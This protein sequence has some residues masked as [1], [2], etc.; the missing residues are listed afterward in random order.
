MGRASLDERVRAAMIDV[1]FEQGPLLVAG[2]LFTAVVLVGLLSG[3]VAPVPLT[4]WS[5]VLAV[6]TA[7]RALLLYRYAKRRSRRSPAPLW[8]WA[9]ALFSTGF[10]LLWGAAALLFIDAGSGYRANAGDLWLVVMIPVVIMGL[11]AVAT[12]ALASFPAAS[13]GFAVSSNLLLVL[14]LF[15]SATE[16]A[17][18]LIALILISLASNLKNGH[19]L[20][21]VLEETLRLRF[22]NQDLRQRF[23]HKSGRLQTTLDNIDQGL[24]LL[25]R[26]GRLAMW[27][28][29]LL[30]LMGAS[31]VSEQTRFDQLSVGLRRVVETDGSYAD[32][33]TLWRR[34]DGACVEIRSTP[35]AD[36]ESVLTV[37]DVTQLERHQQAQLQARFQAEEARRQAEQANIAKTRFLAA[38]SHD[39]RQPVQALAL[40]HRVLEERARG[41][42]LQGLVAQMGQGIETLN[43]LLGNL[44]HISKLEAG[45]EIPERATVEL[46]ALFEQLEREFSRVAAQ[47]H[48]RLRFRP[49]DERVDSDR[50]MLTRIVS[51]LVANAI[52][53]SRNG[54]VLV[55][56]R[57]RGERL[58]IGV[59]D[60]G[61]G[62]PLAHQRRIFEEF[63]QLHNPQRDRSLGLGL[64]LAIVKR[65]AEL[66]GHRVEVRSRVGSGSCFSVWLPRVARPPARRLRQGDLGA[67]PGAMPGARPGAGRDEVLAGRRVWVIDDDP[68]VREALL[69]L[70]DH[71]GCRVQVAADLDAALALAYGGEAADLLLLDYRLPAGVTGLDVAERL[72]GHYG[73]SIPSVLLTG[74]TAPERLREADASGFPLLNKPVSPRVLRETLIEV[75]GLSLDE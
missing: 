16:V 25:D 3:R 71:W 8:G 48:T 59:Y 34:T 11:N 14:A 39:L 52:K 58:R 67:R 69:A 19:T 64:G 9:T 22:E 70:L 66:L 28:S 6:T 63:Q 62:I 44:L 24:A 30:L 56:A 51:N 35:I 42:E 40:V 43:E 72:F 74:D 5:V 75:L 17:L 53:Y 57:P 26:S 7:G 68:I 60:D 32:R 13:I 41:G 10:G 20:Y 55:V 4:L 65:T 1:L 2:T 23:E 31:R 49:T 18:P 50:F 36:G 21:L 46:G 37:S 47:Q 27:N 12:V 33:G 54:R 38:A 45:L 73:R 15:D 61:P 29:R